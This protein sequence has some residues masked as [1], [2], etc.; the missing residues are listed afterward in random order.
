MKPAVMRCVYQLGFWFAAAKKIRHFFSHQ[1]EM[2]FAVT[3]LRS[4]NK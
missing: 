1:S 2:Q 3:Y 4:T